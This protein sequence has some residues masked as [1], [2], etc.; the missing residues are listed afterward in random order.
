MSLENFIL[1]QPL[2]L[3]HYMNEVTITQTS[4][5]LQLNYVLVIRTLQTYLNHAVSN[6]DR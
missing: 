3:L 4:L 5:C 2:E 6:G 1:A